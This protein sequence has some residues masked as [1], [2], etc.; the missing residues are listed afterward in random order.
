[1]T[2]LYEQWD[3]HAAYLTPLLGEEVTVVTSPAQL[4]DVVTGNHRELLVVFGPSTA[5]AEAVAVAEQCRARRPQLG[6]ILLRH[7]LD[8]NVVNEAI[9]AGVREV[10]AISDRESIVAACARSLELSRTIAGDEP[11]PSAPTD[12]QIVAVF[13]GKGG[14]GKSVLATNLAVA[15]A[16][17]DRRRVCL[18][19]LDLAFGDVAI[20]MELPPER[21]ISAAVPVADRIDDVGFRTLLTRHR[22]GV[23]AL[24]A[25]VRPADAELVSRDLITEL[26]YLARG[27]FDHIVVDC[28]STLNEQTLAAL[29]AAHHFFLITTPELPSLKSLRI[30]LDTFDLLSY[31]RERRAVVLNRADSKVGLSAADVERATRMSV[32]ASVPS[33]R[34]V[35]LSINRGTPILLDQPNHPVSVAIRDFARKALL[36]QPGRAHRPRRTLLG[37]RA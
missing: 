33:S 26:L 21:T 32:S 13:S 1:M 18:V 36:G 24:L 14:T 5:L 9:R 35:P 11:D 29:D 7:H 16:Q 31:S 20:M 8:P 4:A 23:S 30:T 19:D 10:V 2:I 37:R 28:A 6:V 22:S 12:G 17:D 25:P 15:L 27:S 34:D 3:K